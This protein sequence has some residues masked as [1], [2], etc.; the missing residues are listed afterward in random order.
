MAIATAT[1]DFDPFGKILTPPPPTAEASAFEALRGCV[2]LRRATID[3]LRA[4]ARAATVR[5]LGRGAIVAA[6][7]GQ[8]D[9]AILVVRGK[10]RA[11]CR[12]ANGR[13]ISV[14]TFRA[15]DSDRRRRVRARNGPSS[16]LGGG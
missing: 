9:A 2:Q 3:A 14:E 7:G 15:G 8:F 4:M 5:S 10:V 13:E 1:L 6:Q 16:R 12:A 11:V